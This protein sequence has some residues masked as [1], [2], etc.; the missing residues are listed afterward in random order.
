[1]VNY[2]TRAEAQITASEMAEYMAGSELK[3]NSVL[4][5]AR[6]RPTVRVRSYG[7]ARKFLAAELIGNS[8][9]PAR[10]HERARRFR[11][12]TSDDD[13]E[14]QEDRMN[15]DMLERYATVYPRIQIP[16]ASFV[17]PPQKNW[18]WDISGLKISIA[19]HFVILDTNRAGEEISGAGV[20]EYSK[21]KP[22]NPE[23]ARWFSTLLCLYAE[24]VPLRGEPAY[25]LSGC[26]DVQTGQFHPAPERRTR[27][28]QLMEAAALAI[29]QRWSAI[30]RPR[31]AGS[32]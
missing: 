25:R 20:F 1:M 5:A 4:V 32:N 6:H 23:T 29:A 3:K 12:S 14:R 19:P 30:P 17:A 15:A 16:G 7:K 2:T 13:F 28:L 24:N 10:I 31:P 21:G 8:Q 11:E 18:V 9:D 26:L 27:L 22:Y